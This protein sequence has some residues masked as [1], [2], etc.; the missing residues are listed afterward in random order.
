MEPKFDESPG[1]QDVDI[2]A[3]KDEAVL[4]RSLPFGA[5]QYVD[6]T[7][8]AVADADTDIRHSLRTD[9]PEAI[10]WE[11]VQWRFDAPPGGGVVVYK[12]VSATRRPWGRGY[13]ILRCNLA[14]VA[15]TLRLSI[16]RR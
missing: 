4:R 8:N 3:L 1:G 14:S 6:V 15:A 16:R 13:V 10:D 11:V 7:F 12:D 2:K 9:D 5:Y